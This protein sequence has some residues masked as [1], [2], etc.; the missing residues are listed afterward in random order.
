MSGKMR[1][2]KGGRRKVK[3]LEAMRAAELRR[4]AESG[5]DYEASRDIPHSGHTTHQQG[6][7]LAKN[8]PVVA[9]QDHKAGL[10]R[11]WLSRSTNR[12]GLR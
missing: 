11:S 2:K 3:R 5:G 1:K 7:P 8:R 9:K 6:A 10:G 12:Q 4:H